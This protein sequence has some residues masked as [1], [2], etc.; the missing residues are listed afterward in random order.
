MIVY[1]LKKKKKEKKKGKKG[2][3]RERERG[4][5][6]IKGARIFVGSLSNL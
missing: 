1:A 4:R 5:R 2:E 6:R 3:R